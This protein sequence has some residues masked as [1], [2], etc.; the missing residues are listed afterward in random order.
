MKLV[1]PARDKAL[2]A[3]AIAVSLAALA[4]V[5]TGRETPTMDLAMAKPGAQEP[6]G[7]APELHLAKLERRAAPP[8]QGDPFAPRS[9]APAPRPA[10]A[11]D[12][13]QPSA[14][15]LPFR[16]AGRLTQNGTTEVFVARGEELI[17]IAPGQAIDGE[18]RVDAISASRIGFTYLPLKTQQSL[19]VAET[20]G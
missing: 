9:F 20:D 18:Y 15:P 17:A 11:P 14:P 13:A 1:F 16:Y 2:R 5:V 10:R 7:A 12:A 4:G 6:A 8:T 19:E 3:A